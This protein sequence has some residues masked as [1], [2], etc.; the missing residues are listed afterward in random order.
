VIVSAG[1]DNR[2]IIWDVRSRAAV[3]SVYG[4]KVYGDSVDVAGDRILVGSWRH[5]EQLQMYDIGSGELLSD[6]PWNSSGL[7]ES[8]EPCMV[9]TT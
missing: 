6:V 8:D 1:W 7:P 5:F 3:H 2:V 4:P 9:Y